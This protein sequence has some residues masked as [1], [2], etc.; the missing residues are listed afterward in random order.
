MKTPHSQ[1]SLARA[2]S[3]L[4]LNDEDVFPQA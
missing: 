3:E 1:Y 2:H 4:N